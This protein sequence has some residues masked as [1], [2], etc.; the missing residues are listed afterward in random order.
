MVEGVSQFQAMLRRKAG[1]AIEAGKA[2]AIK[3]GEDLAQAQRFL[4]PVDDA[5]LLRS[6]RV[7]PAEQIKT[8]QGLRDFVGV[9][10]KAGDETTM[11]TNSSGGRFQNARLQEFGTKTRAANPYFFPAWRANRRR[12]RASITRAIRKVWTS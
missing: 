8:S 3:G 1:A 2:A 11:V 10:V 12:I 5:D 7:E 6:I 9:A 4:A